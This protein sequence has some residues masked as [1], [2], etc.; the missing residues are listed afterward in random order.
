MA[1]HVESGSN[2]SD[3]ELVRTLRLK[4]EDLEKKVYEDVYTAQ[5]HVDEGRRRV[6]EAEGRKPTSE[7]LSGCGGCGGSGCVVG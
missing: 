5:R 2:M 6:S 4:V 3:G 1:I 7:D